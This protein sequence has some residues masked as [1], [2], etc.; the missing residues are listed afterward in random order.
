MT[1]SWYISQKNKLES[2]IKESVCVCVNSAAGE[3][4]GKVKACL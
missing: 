4:A 3:K 1:Y 2:E